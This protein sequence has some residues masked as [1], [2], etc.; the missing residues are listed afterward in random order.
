[1]KT[2][3]FLLLIL[4][5]SSLAAGVSAQDTVIVPDLTGL[6]V[7]QAAAALNNAELLLGAENAELWTE[8]SSVPQGSVLNQSLPPGSEASSGTAVDL[9]ILYPANIQI[10]Y[11]NND[12]TLINHAGIQLNLNQIT[13]ASANG[14]ASFQAANWRGDLKDG[15]CGQ[16]WSINRS[17]PKA[18][19]GC[20]SIYWLTRRDTALH[21]WTQDNGVSE[22]SMLLGGIELVTCPAAPSG[23]QDNPLTCE[24]F[25][26]GG[27]SPSSI[28]TAFLYFVYTSNYLA[29][30]NTADDLWMPLDQTPILDTNS[31][32]SF[33]FSA[34]E[35]Y[36]D[37]EIV[38]DI[39]RLA[40]GQCIVFTVGEINPV[41]PDL[42][43]NVIV[44]QAVTSGTAIWI[45]GF[46]VQSSVDEKRRVCPPARDRLNLCVMQR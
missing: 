41:A 23:S 44:Q 18:T 14:A 16:I 17:D 10:V 4:L 35:L 36:G 37:Q 6:N 21:F 31:Q 45:N 15:D 26:P 28:N 9:T 38:G 33:L 1:M 5:C 32:N 34:S 30:V 40:P 29:V 20:N 27:L 12:L 25:F 8:T 3:R 39:N 43:D 2:I 24:F 19:E 46:K 42:C 22:F 7:P 11:D 13:F